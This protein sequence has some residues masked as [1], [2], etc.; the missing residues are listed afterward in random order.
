MEIMKNYHGLRLKRD[1]SLLGYVFE[2][3]RKKLQK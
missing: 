2:T 3:F 1:V